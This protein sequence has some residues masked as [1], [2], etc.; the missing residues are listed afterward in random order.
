MTILITENI[1]V[2]LLVPQIW[3]RLPKVANLGFAASIPI[4][5]LM[6]WCEGQIYR[7]LIRRM[8]V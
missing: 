5:A 4:P 6:G 8:I 1:L 7:V 2:A 3:R